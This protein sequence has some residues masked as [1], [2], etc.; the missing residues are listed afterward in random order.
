MSIYDRERQRKASQEPKNAMREPKNTTR[1]QSPPCDAEPKNAIAAGIP[2]HRQKSPLRKRLIAKIHIAKKDLALTDDSYIALLH[3]ATHKHSCRHMTIAELQTVISV[4]KTYGWKPKRKKWQK[5]HNPQV[6]MVYRLWWMLAEYGVV[7][8][9]SRSACQH[10]FNRTVQN[11]P[12]EWASVG[13]LV[14]AIERLKKW[15]RRVGNART[16]DLMI[17]DFNMEK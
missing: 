5:S 8:S 10:W 1:L 7:K 13:D 11:T 17:N 3:Q 12:I 15:G 14:L 16:D 4:F 9:K 6:R 2:P